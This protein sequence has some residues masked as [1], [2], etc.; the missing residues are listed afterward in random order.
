MLP[1]KFEKILR[2]FFN[3]VFN[4][5]GGDRP[6]AKNV[7]LLFTDGEAADPHIARAESKDLKESG[8]HVISI[9]FGPKKS[10]ARFKEEMEVM[11]SS[12]EDD[13][14]LREFDDLDDI[15]R[16]I[17]EV[18]QRQQ[19]KLKRMKLTSFKVLEKKMRTLNLVV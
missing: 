9:G 4:G 15:E 12:K 2:L 14:F 16:R 18:A 17:V 5:K 3:Q 6:Y 7:L 8:A 13:V 19:R 11:A 1:E 10:V